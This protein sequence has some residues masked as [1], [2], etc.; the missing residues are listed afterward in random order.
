VARRRDRVKLATNS[1]ASG[2]TL[3]VRDYAAEAVEPGKGALLYPALSHRHEAGP[4]PSIRDANGWPRLPATDYAPP[5]VVGPRGY[6]GHLSI[7]LTRVAE[8]LTLAPID[9]LVGS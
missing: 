5:T 7:S 3:I 6:R 9:T 2:L 8:R 4:C 1:Q